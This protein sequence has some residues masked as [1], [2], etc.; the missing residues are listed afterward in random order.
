MGV[1]ILGAVGIFRIMQAAILRQSAD[2]KD[3]QESW[4]IIMSVIIGAVVM[5]GSLVILRVIGVN[6]LGILPFD[7]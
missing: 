7:F 3:I 4:D 1:G 5:M 2:P 6:V